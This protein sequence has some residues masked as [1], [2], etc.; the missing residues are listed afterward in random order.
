MSLGR[1]LVAVRDTLRTEL[2]DWDQPFAPQ[3][4]LVMPGPEPAPYCGQHFISVYG[5][6]WIAG[7]ESDNHRGLDELYG[8]SC[9]LSSRSPVYPPD[10][11]G[12]ELYVKLYTGMEDICRKIMIAVHQSIVVQ[13]A[14]DALLIGK[15][16]QTSYHLSTE[17]LRWQDTDAA[18][19]VVDGTWF[20]AA[21]DEAAGLVMEVRFSKARRMQALDRLE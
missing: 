15:T 14:W 4:I 12:D 5:L 8:I 2:V 19:Q 17:Y 13:Q 21:P 11:R 18:P 16:R 1:L 7:G 6:S 10:R 3:D 20:S 9:A